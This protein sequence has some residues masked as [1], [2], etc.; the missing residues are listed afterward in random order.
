[1]CG[2]SPDRRCG[3]L[4]LYRPLNTG[5]KILNY[6]PELWSYGDSNSGPLACHQQAMR[7]QPYIR[8]GQRLRTSAPV[9]PDPGRLRYFS[10]VLPRVPAGVHGRCGTFRPPA[11]RPRRPGP[12]SRID[13]TLLHEL[14]ALSARMLMRWPARSPVALK[15][16]VSLRSASWCCH[17]S[18]EGPAGYLEAFR[19]LCDVARVLLDLCRRRV[20]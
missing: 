14:R 10:A 1:V 9:L 7:P 16:L 6:I 3:T 11:V 20:I 4:L 17:A 18:L 13:V 2:I 12:S 15:S 5:L 8:A 19:G